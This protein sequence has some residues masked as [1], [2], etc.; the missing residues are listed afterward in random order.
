MASFI[1]DIKRNM[2]P[3]WRN[4]NDTI[5]AKELEFSKNIILPIS[6]NHFELFIDAWRSK[7]TVVTAANLV[8]AAVAS[9]HQSQQ[10]VLQAADFLLNH[11]DECSLLALDVAKSIVNIPI[12]D[13][14]YPKLEEHT[15]EE[16]AD[17]LIQDLQT[18]ENSLKASIGLL[19][20]QIHNHCYNP[21]AYCELARSYAS[22]G[23]DDKAKHYMNYAVFLAPHN[24][25]ISRCAARF[26]VHIREYDRAK[27]ILLNNGY[28]KSDPWVLAAEIAV[29]SVMDRSS[30]YLKIGRQLVLSGNISSFSSGELCLAICHEDRNSGKRKDAKQMYEKGMIDPNDNCLAQA[31]FY[32]K[33][34]GISNINFNSFQQ[35]SHKNEADTRKALSEEK[36]EEAFI[37]SLKWMQ[38][39]RF[40]HRPT[41][42]AFGISCDYLKRYDYAISIVKRSLSINPKDPAAI[43][44]L[45]YVLGL[46]NR[47]EEAEFILEG[48]KKHQYI[49]EN[50][51]SPNGICLLATCGLI[52]YRKGNI[53][54]GRELYNT[55]IMA[56]NKQKN[57]DLSAKARLNMIREEVHCVDNYDPAL[58]NEMES[59]STGNRAE[60]DQLK[61]DIRD[62]V[63]KKVGNN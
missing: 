12:L 50:N 17:K 20:R 26:Y 48:I 3:L 13:K 19:K 18:Q 47:V 43:N 32:A 51:V 29:E 5:V 22:L 16:R 4:Y 56:A 57:K 23:M 33:E 24:R 61:Q 7:Q 60:T 58:L 52:E 34:D 1:D 25:Y 28:V 15:F 54:E 2:L 31:E 59:L 45:V 9:G 44:N 11:P 8:N 36:Y 42:F 14:N 46:S 37:S 53:V 27:R 30:H 40:E 49:S 62:E 63:K 6:F 35:I 10:N 41:E 39:Y 38:D 55:A 21:I